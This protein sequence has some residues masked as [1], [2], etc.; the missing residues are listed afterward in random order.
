MFL[1]QPPLSIFPLFSRIKRNKLLHSVLKLFNTSV[2]LLYPYFILDVVLWKTPEVRACHAS[3]ISCFVQNLEE[4][5]PEYK[6]NQRKSY[7]IISCTCENLRLF[8]ECCAIKQNV[9]SICDLHII[10]ENFKPYICF[11]KLNLPI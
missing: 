3:N 7:R 9:I 10:L 2:S 5:H 1:K 11:P 8:I 6:R 4:N